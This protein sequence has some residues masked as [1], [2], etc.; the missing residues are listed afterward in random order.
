MKMPHFHLERKSHKFEAK[1]IETG[2]S[3]LPAE[4]VHL[5]HFRSWQLSRPPTAVQTQDLWCGAKSL[6]PLS[7]PSNTTC[8][9]HNP[10]FKCPR[11]SITNSISPLL[12]DKSYQILAKFLTI[13]AEVKIWQ[14]PTSDQILFP[15]IPGALRYKHIWSYL[16]AW[17][18][19]LP[20][21]HQS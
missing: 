20:F 18:T 7:R 4:I 6:S 19:H 15:L 9:R 1:P 14:C 11:A 10:A 2:L 17:E 16:I 8:D 12:R 5:S 21:I 3:P 13:S